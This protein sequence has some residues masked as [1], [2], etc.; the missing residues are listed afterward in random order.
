M[1]TDEIIISRLSGLRLGQ[2][3]KAQGR[4]RRAVSDKE[5][6]TLMVVNTTGAA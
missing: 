3:P 6:T 1:G 5:D 4:R 2:A